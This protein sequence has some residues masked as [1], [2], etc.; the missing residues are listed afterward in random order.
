MTDV[1]II[2]AAIEEGDN[3]GQNGECESEEDGNGKPGSYSMALQC[4]DTLV[5]WKSIGFEYSDITLKKIQIVLRRS[6][7]FTTNKHYG[8]SVKINVTCINCDSPNPLEFST[9][10][11]VLLV[12][13]KVD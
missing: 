6:L 9:D 5:D 8:A 3:D 2:S 1:D 11:R 7:K 4:V 12:I 10:A 13:P